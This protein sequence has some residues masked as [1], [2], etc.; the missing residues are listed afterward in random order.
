MCL[1]FRAE[2]A[3][4]ACDKREETQALAACREDAKRSIYNQQIFECSRFQE[5]IH[6]PQS[7]GQ[8]P[9]VSPTSGWHWPSPQ[10]LQTPQSWG[11]PERQTQRNRGESQR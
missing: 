4:S 11:Q 6:L 10:L 3:D 5:M 9:Q 8:L 2:T 1:T 7:C